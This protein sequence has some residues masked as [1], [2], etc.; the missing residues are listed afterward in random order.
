M[1]SLF[2]VITIAL[3]PTRAVEGEYLIGI[4]SYDMTG[5]TAG[6][7]MMGYANMDQIS[8]GIHLRLRPRTFIV[9]ESS[10]VPTFAFVNLDAGMASPLV[11]IKVLKRLTLRFG[12]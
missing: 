10:R 4:G 2:V 6:V 8:A 11:T 5:P 12:D 7:S 1:L 9:A 3:A